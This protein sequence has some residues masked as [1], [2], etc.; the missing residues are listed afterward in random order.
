MHSSL[1]VRVLYRVQTRHRIRIIYPN[2]KHLLFRQPQPLPL[3]VATTFVGGL[4]TDVERFSRTRGE[5]TRQARSIHP[6]DGPITTRLL[7][8]TPEAVTTKPVPSSTGQATTPTTTINTTTPTTT[9]TTINT[10]TSTSTS[11]STTT[12][13]ARFI[14]SSSDE[15]KMARGLRIYGANETHPI[16][17]CPWSSNAR[18][19]RPG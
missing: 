9:T 16:R 12:C 8:S 4:S 15:R 19:R 5:A 7:L 18:P 13:N 11:T 1:R 3:S 10:T 14:Y 6:Q 17:G 2:H